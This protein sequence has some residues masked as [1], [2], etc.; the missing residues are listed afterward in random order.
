MIFG[1]VSFNQPGSNEM[2]DLSLSP[3]H[4]DG[5]DTMEEYFEFTTIPE[6]VH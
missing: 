2:G 1:P 5:V 4:L 3:S 6:W